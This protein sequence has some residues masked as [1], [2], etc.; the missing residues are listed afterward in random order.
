[1]TMATLPSHILSQLQFRQE[2]APNTLPTGIDPLDA[3]IEGCPRGRITEIV[4]PQSS[5]R[6]TLLHATLAEGTRL[7]EFCAVIDTAN[8]FD[9]ASAEAAGV[10]LRRIVLVRC[11]GNPEHAIKSADLL[12]HSGGFGIVAFDLCEVP[13]RV[14]RRIPTSWWYRFRRAIENTPTVFLILS[15]EP[16][17]K[18]CA[19]LFLE[20]KREGAEFAGVMP[21]QF[22]NA[23]RFHA[24]PRKPVRPTPARFEA[25]ALR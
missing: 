22:L 10:D 14:T 8:A 19:S 21:F 25:R 11:N 7:G 20:I 4:G 15:S 23:A 9:P 12:V 17:A 24:L 5:G 1:M 13:A 2:L 18:A 16:N 6:T 3:A